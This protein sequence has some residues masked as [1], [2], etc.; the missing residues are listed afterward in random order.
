MGV[1][2][3]EGEGPVGGNAIKMDLIIASR[4]VVAADAT[5]CRIM[6]INP[7]EIQHIKLLKKEDWE[8]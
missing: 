3:Q 6:G 2:A 8:T 4:D 7:Y 1:Y 5:A